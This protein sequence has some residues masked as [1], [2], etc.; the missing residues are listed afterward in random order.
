MSVI[1]V[2]KTDN[3]KTGPVSVTMVSQESCPGSCP[4][5]DNCCYAEHG[6][7]GVTTRRLNHSE[8]KRADTIARKEAAAI[9]GLSGERPLRPHIVGDCR[10]RNAA[11]I[12]SAACERYMDRYYQWNQTDKNTVWTYTHAWDDPEKV[13][14]SDWGRVSCV[15]SCESVSQAEAAT[16]KGWAVA[17]IVGEFVSE[18]VYPLEGTSLRV[19]PCPY[20]TRGITCD[21]CRLCWDDRRLFEA[22]LVIGFLAHGARKNSVNTLLE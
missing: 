9:D 2:E 3:R 10:T 1:A 19:I 17:L 11:R 14:R 22:G 12:V 4:L 18:K 21:K 15:A 13:E 20:Q 5:K 16:A 8:D 7:L 6:P